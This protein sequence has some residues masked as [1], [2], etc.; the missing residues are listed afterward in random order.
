[1]ILMYPF[2]TSFLSTISVVKHLML[3]R[4]RIKLPSA[5]VTLCGPVSCEIGTHPAPKN[6]A[7]CACISV[8]GIFLRRPQKYCYGEYLALSV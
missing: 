1:M 2:C 8:S 4:M 7:L 6:S 5:R 3:M